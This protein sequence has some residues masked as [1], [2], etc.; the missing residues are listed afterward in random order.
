ML[1]ARAIAMI[2]TLRRYSVA[3]PLGALLL[4]FWASPDLQEVAAG[5]AVFLFGILMLQDGFKLLGGGKLDRV[6]EAATR[7]TPRALVFGFVSTTLVQSSSLV[8]VLTISFL[9][10][11]LISLIGGIGIVFGANLGTTTGAWLVAGLGLNVD[12]A[13]YAMPMIALSVVLV[14]QK[15]PA[16]RGLGYVL[17]GIGFLFLGIHHMK[18]G[19]EAFRDGIDLADY[20][21][22]G[23]AGLLVYTLVGAVATV[24]LQS[25]HATMVLAITA[26]AAGQITYENAIPLAIG[27]N[28]GTTVTALIGSVGAG[29]QGR[30]LALAHLIFNLVT[31]AVALVFVMQLTELVDIVAQGVGVGDENHSLKLAIFH[32]I[33]NLLGVVLMLPLLRRLAGF[34]ERRVPEPAA[35]VSRPRYLNE[36]M[37][38]FPEALATALRKEVMHLYENATKLILH[39]MNLHRETV[40]AAD[41]IAA[42]VRRSRSPIDLD[43]GDEYERRVKTL[44]AA[45]VDFATHATRHRE[46]APDVVA[47]ID[48]LRDIAGGLV[49]SVKSVKHIRKNLLRYT[50]A[51]RGAATELYDE[52]RTEVARVV[53][54]IRDLEREDPDDRSPL[55]LDQEAARLA[56][57]ARSRD[58]RVGALIEARDL[59]PAAATSF[60]NDASYADAAMRELLEAAR[61]YY[62]AENEAVAEVEGLLALDEEELGAALG[63]QKPG[64]GAARSAAAAAPGSATEVSQSSATVHAKGT[65]ERPEWD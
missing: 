30:R 53:I 37:G 58:R 47:R 43:I 15:A 46:T 41:D 57:S 20:A 27:T 9:S 14:F 16:M 55:W 11:G 36:A 48:A 50:T 24:I 3:L 40:F 42:A 17:A 56:A 26:L 21:L 10:A 44:Y 7:S 35:D 29:Y 22:P 4:A 49:R 19:F 31:A 28:V 25:S 63:R 23:V 65:S 32:T 39:G 64:R 6:L 45:I 13:S 34:L 62:A 52:L 12:I 51:D 1:Y 8:T 5:V 60:L 18:V 59:D 33:F 2:A 54:A 38:D 61:A